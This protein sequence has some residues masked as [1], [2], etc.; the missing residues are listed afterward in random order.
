M[1]SKVY[2]LGLALCCSLLLG[3]NVYASE[4]ETASVYTTDETS[5]FTYSDGTVI[6]C[7]LNEYGDPYIYDEYGEKLY[8]YT[9][10]DGTTIEYYLNEH[11]VPY[12]YRDGEQVF[13]VIT[14]DRYRVT[15]QRVIDALNGNGDLIALYSNGAMKV[16]PPTTYFDCSN[17]ATYSLEDINF[18]SASTWATEN[19]YYGYNNKTLRVSTFPFT[20]RLGR[21]KY[22]YLKTYFYDEIDQTWIMYED[23]YDCAVIEGKSWLRTPNYTYGRFLIESSDLKTTTLNVWLMNIWH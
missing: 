5:T 16:A 8:M 19:L 22:V 13:V 7:Y 3:V 6:D 1:R 18:D 11:D 14:L 2:I 17:G 23:E 20:N 15:D 10:P 9:Y 21:G 12:T 4:N